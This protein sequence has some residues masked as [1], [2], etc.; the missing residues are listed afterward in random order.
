MILKLEDVA[1]RDEN[2]LINLVSAL[3]PGQRVR[4]TVWRDRQAQTV[5][6]TVGDYPGQ[7]DRGRG[8]GSD[9]QRAQSAAAGSP[10]VADRDRALAGCWD[11]SLLVARLHPQ[12]DHHADEGEE[13]DAHPD[14]H[15]GLPE[16]VHDRVH[17]AVPFK[18]GCEGMNGGRVR[19][20][21]RSPAAGQ[22]QRNGVLPARISAMQVPGRKTS[23]SPHRA[24]SLAAGY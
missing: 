2:H 21:G 8:D 14:H 9:A 11:G 5:D 16:E 12:E 4:L 18:V 6:V 24:A 1:L 19:I 10:S 7:Q 13:G 22:F 17:R 23:P 3:P 20:A 15:P